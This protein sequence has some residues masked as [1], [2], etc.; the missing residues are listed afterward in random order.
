MPLMAGAQPGAGGNA[1]GLL[2]GWA[3]LQQG[4][5]DRVFGR[6]RFRTVVA[7]NHMVLQEVGGGG[8]TCHGRGEEAHATVG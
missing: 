6:G 1:R 3:R 4:L 5:L 7:G 2:A 8:G